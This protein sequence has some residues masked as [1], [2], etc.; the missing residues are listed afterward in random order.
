MWVIV[1]MPYTA[2][3]ESLSQGLRTLRISIPESSAYFL[4]WCWILNRGKIMEDI[5]SDFHR[6][7]G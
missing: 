4:E 5:H 3:A 2:F 7:G 6:E 1:E